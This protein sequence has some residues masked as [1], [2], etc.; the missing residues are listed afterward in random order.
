MIFLICSAVLFIAV[1]SVVPKKLPK[2][3]LYVIALFSM[4]LGLC[5][6]IVLS[7][8]YHLYGYFSPGIQLESFLVILILFPS[9]GVMFMNFY[10]FKKSL[11]NQV[12]YII[13]WNIFCLLFE[14]A[15]IISGY[16][17]HNNWNYWYSAF[18][19]PLLF[20]IHLFQLKFF[21]TYSK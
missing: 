18:S 3:E 19:Y 21:R 16:F 20:L 6:D 2:C 13:C 1:V 5:T 11:I 8:K 17:Y 15:S 12:F 9:S 14:Y 4:I 7:L 10:P